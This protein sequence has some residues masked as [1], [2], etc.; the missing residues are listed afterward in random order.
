MAAGRVRASRPETADSVGTAPAE[1]R[2]GAKAWV[3]V[4]GVLILLGIV[5]GVLV[6]T[7]RGQTTLPAAGSNPSLSPIVDA[8]GSPVKVT[9]ARS[10]TKPGQVVVTFTSDDPDASD[11][12]RVTRTDDGTGSKPKDE[13][14]TSP[15]S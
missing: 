7:L 10:A 9:V 6:A 4:V 5:G 8:G 3:L 14:A 12:Y 15:S 1:D 2:P 13:L 11:V